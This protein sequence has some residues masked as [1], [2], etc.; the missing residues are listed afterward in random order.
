[1]ASS[2]TSPGSLGAVSGSLGLSRGSLGALLGSL[3]AFLGLSWGSFGALLGSLDAPS[4]ALG[5]SWVCLG[6]SQGFQASSAT[7]ASRLPKLPGIHQHVC[8]RQLVCS[9]PSLSACVW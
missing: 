7:L 8:D 6:L 1:M 9:H 4:G 3:G 2:G 5:H